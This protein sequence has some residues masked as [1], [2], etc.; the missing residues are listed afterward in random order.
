MHQILL[1]FGPKSNEF[2]PLAAYCL[3]TFRR[4]CGP[5]SSLRGY[6]VFGGL[7]T[8]KKNQWYEN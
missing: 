4:K 2:T 3:A 6:K 5:P 1:S 8:R 7:T